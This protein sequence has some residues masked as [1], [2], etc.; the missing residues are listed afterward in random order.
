MVEETYAS[1]IQLYS[2]SV[3]EIKSFLLTELP[4]HPNPDISTSQELAR[5]YR[6]N[7]ALESAANIRR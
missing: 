2:F 5:L 4:S 6:S 1:P 7:E 3:R